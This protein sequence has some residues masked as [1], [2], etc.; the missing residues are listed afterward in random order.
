MVIWL[1]PPLLQLSTWFMTDPLKLYLYFQVAVI[2]WVQLQIHFY[3]ASFLKDFEEA[4]M[5][6]GD[7][8]VADILIKVSDKPVP[9]PK[10]LQD[11]H[12]LQGPYVPLK[13]FDYNY[14]VVHWRLEWT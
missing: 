14:W 6:F 4:F 10:R 9:V 2:T 3:I 8:H 1:T 12:K 11:P 13:K 5:M 7:T